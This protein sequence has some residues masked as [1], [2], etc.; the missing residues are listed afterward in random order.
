M[1][2]KKYKITNELGLSARPATKLVNEIQEFSCEIKVTVN[3]TTANLKSIMGVIAI[4]AF[5]GE[6]LEVTCSGSDEE[7]A[8]RRISL[9]IVD[10]SLGKEI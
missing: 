8:M 9:M 10:L 3:H 6:V 7:E 2:T 5:K 1:I 4:G